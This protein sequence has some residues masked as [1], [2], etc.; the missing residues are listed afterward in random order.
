MFN[1]FFHE[2]D[3]NY[4]KGVETYGRAR[5]VADDNTIRS[6]LLVLGK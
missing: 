1:N 2:N 3:A 5:Q 6:M 4:E